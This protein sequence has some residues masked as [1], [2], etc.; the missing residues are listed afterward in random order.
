MLIMILNVSYVH[1]YN[2]TAV[3]LYGQYGKRNSY[4]MMIH[5]LEQDLELSYFT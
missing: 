3:M 2:D 5:L 1:I 4:L